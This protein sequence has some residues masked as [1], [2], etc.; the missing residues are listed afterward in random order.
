MLKLAMRFALEYLLKKYPNA[1]RVFL[2]GS[3]VNLTFEEYQKRLVNNPKKES[4][5]DI[6]LVF[7]EPRFISGVDF[8]NEVELFRCLFCA[9]ID[10]FPVNLGVL[11]LRRVKCRVLPINRLT[12]SL[13]DPQDIKPSDLILEKYADGYIS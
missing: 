3:R 6:V 8:S 9:K 10:V 2:K 4:D 5:F 13:I 1:K 7:D 12:V 11:P